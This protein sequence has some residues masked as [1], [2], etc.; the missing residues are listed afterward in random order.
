MRAKSSLFFVFDSNAIPFFNETTEIGKEQRANPLWNKSQSI[1]RDFLS[2]RVTKPN[3]PFWLIID[4]RNCSRACWKWNAA[5]SI[6]TNWCFPLGND[7]RNG[8]W[9]ILISILSDFGYSRAVS[10]DVSHTQVNTFLSF[11]MK[12]STVGPLRWMSPESLKHSEYSTAS[13]VW[14]FGISSS[15]SNV[16]LPGATLIEIYTGH[17]PC[18]SET[19]LVYASKILNRQYSPVSEIPSQ[20]TGKLRTV[21]EGCFQFQPKLRPSFKEIYQILETASSF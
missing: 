21:M 1:S 19:A 5:N 2:L 18:P 15:F 8:V 17:P 9:V 10:E 3:Q 4:T 20:V 11:S 16:N 13:D 7:P 6:R 14:A 12:Q